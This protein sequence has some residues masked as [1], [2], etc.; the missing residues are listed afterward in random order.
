MSLVL[1]D[2]KDDNIIEICSEILNICKE[3]SYTI[4]TCESF[5]GGLI[6]SNITNI[7]GSSDIYYGGFVTYMIDAKVD[8]LGIE[9][10]F[11][12]EYGVVSHEVAR[13]MAIKAKEIL[14]TDI[15]ISSTG[16]AG[17]NNGDENG[18]FFVA[19]AIGDEI[20]SFEER[21]ELDRIGVKN[22]GATIALAH[23][24]EYIDK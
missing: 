6:A 11:I 5:T 20:Y 4:S 3:K 21:I 18:H 16:Y 24:L 19:I 2:M 17:P 7:A 9:R 1:T 23:L 10:D 8:I 14:N 13:K 22:A 15:S 12:N